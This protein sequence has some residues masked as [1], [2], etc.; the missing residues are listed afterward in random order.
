V[1]SIRRRWFTRQ[2]SFGCLNP[3]SDFEG[4]VPFS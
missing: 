2:L 3:G 4:Q 1:Q